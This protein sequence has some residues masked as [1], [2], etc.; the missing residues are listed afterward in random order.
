[1]ELR[2]ALLH[3]FCLHHSCSLRAPS[4]KHTQ[5]LARL[6]KINVSSSHSIFCSTGVTCVSVSTVVP[7]A[8]KCQGPQRWHGP[9]RV[10]ISGPEKESS[11]KW[12][13]GIASLFELVPRN[14]PFCF[15]EIGTW[16]LVPQIR[17]SREGNKNARQQLGAWP[18]CS[19]QPL[20]CCPLC[21]NT[22]KL[23]QKNDSAKMEGFLAML[24]PKETSGQFLWLSDQVVSKMELFLF[25]LPLDKWLLK[26][27][28][29]LSQMPLGLG[30]QFGS[31]RQ[32]T[33]IAYSKIRS[34]GMSWG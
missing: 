28:Q 6:S 18:F 24:V 14:S 13:L 19:L 27:N 25:A 23:A 22:P 8:T 11:T 31:A 12:Q 1:M 10:S 7:Q 4:H 9:N 17:I 29:N 5:S 30:L 16:H 33:Q 15:R 34:F 2:P 20:T 26:V 32:I 21:W 3:H